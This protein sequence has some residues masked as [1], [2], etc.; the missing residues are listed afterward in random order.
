MK[1]FAV[2]TGPSCGL[3]GPTLFIEQMEKITNEC[4]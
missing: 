1:K 2:T 3:C 4:A